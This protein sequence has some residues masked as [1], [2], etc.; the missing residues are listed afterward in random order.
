MQSNQ[1]V[2]WSDEQWRRVQQTVLDEA[3]KARVAARFLPVFGPLP[4]DAETVPAQ[5]LSTEAGDLL[6]GPAELRLAVNDHAVIH[7]TTLS[8][9][10]ALTTA[11]ANQPDLGSALTMFRR[12]ANI[13]AR[14]ED[15]IVFLGQPGRGEGPS[16][17]LPKVY[18]VGGGAQSR[19]LL[20]SAAK[21]KRSAAKGAKEAGKSLVPEVAAGIAELESRGHVGPYALALGNEAFTAAETPDANSFVLPSDRI[22]PMLDG[23][24]LR[25]GML[26]ANA[27]LLVSLAGD[28]VELVVAADIAVRFVQVSVEP[29]YIY[30]VSE[31]IAL[32]VREESALLTFTV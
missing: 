2:E 21:L 26:P 20:E 8:V 31:R 25:A 16:L 3:H 14:V 19:G 5:S 9:N 23:P 1:A 7:L 11:Q 17:P 30:R 4:A 12:A 18:R 28:P 22:R 32:R 10:V 6:S 29:R 15:A 13:I 27:A 24:L